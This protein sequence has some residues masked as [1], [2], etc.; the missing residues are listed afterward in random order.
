MPREVGG[1]A[2][3]VQPEREVSGEIGRSSL[4][5]FEKAH[6]KTELTFQSNTRLGQR[7]FESETLFSN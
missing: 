1:G 6:S 3:S 4:L 2:T 5:A 7:C